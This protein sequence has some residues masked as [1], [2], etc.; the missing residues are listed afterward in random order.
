MCQIDDLAR[1]LVKV[2][3]EAHTTAHDEAQTL[4]DCTE[5]GVV[6]VRIHRTYPLDCAQRN[7]HN[8]RESSS[9]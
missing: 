2:V 3:A 1:S 7:Y 8:V 5:A 6:V 4:A 9:L